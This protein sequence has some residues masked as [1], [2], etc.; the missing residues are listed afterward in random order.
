MKYMLFIYPDPTV[1]LSV[2]ER[3]AIPSAV[4]GWIAEMAARGVREQGHA[5]AQAGDSKTIRIRGGELTI[6][7]GPASDLP[8]QIAGFNI[9]DCADPDEAMEVAAKHPVAAFGTLELRAFDES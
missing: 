4:G 9:L 6:H 1:E 3:A 7:D 8:A 2:E 5:L